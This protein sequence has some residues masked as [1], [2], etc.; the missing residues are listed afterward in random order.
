MNDDQLSVLGCRLEGGGGAV[1]PE[2]WAT[3]T[4]YGTGPRVH[5]ISKQ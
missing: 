4:S 3:V 2:R 5:Q 1:A